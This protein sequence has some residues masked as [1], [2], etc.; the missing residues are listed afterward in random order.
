[1]TRESLEEVG[2][3][4]YSICARQFPV[5]VTAVEMN[6]LSRKENALINGVHIVGYPRNGKIRQLGYSNEQTEKT[7][8]RTT[9]TGTKMVAGR[10]LSKMT[11][12]RVRNLQQDWPT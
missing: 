8:T 2:E 4:D 5:K 12:E 11:K 9:W 1:M 6:G 7:M 10:T 3:V